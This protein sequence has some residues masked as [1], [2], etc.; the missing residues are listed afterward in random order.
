MNLNFCCVTSFKLTSLLHIAGVLKLK[1][2]LST[3][4]WYLWGALMPGVLSTHSVNKSFEFSFIQ[5]RNFPC[6]QSYLG[7]MIRLWWMIWTTQK[8][9]ILFV[10][11]NH[12]DIVGPLIKVFQS[13]DKNALLVE[14]A[15]C[16]MKCC[17]AS[18]PQ[19]FPTQENVP[20]F[21]HNFGRAVVYQYHCV[22]CCVFA[23]S[24]PTA[25]MLMNFYH[26]EIQQDGTTFKP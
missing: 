5:K 7:C 25:V 14:Q 2:S 26:C 8:I 11:V 6:F 12:L 19:L 1:I 21:I 18:F 4:Q 20:C 3:L 17:S 24:V 23:T 16:L 9:A 22:S 15:L 13:R 10:I